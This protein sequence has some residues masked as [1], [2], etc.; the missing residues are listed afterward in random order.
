MLVGSVAKSSFDFEAE[1]IQ[2]AR[3]LATNSRFR[4][5]S[6]MAAFRVS[7]TAPDDLESM[8]VATVGV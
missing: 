5:G 7:R 8:P 4:S 6:Q 3:G 1:A 2:K